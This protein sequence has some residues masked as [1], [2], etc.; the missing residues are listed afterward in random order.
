LKQ[1]RSNLDT[2]AWKTGRLV[3]GVFDD[4]LPGGPVELIEITA[5][6]APDRTAAP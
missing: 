2:Y 3:I 5:P 6:P 4:A 1:G